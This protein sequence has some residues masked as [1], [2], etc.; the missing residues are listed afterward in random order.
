MSGSSTQSVIVA[1][2]VGMGVANF[3]I[4]YVPIAVLSHVRLPDAVLRWLSFVP[5][6]VMGALVATQVLAPKGAIQPPLTNPGVYAAVLT[7]LAFRFTR[8][9]LGATVVG[10]VSFVVLRALIG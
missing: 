3:A 5:I 8:S 6:S 9:F 4:R 1:V 7:A 10:M 2:I